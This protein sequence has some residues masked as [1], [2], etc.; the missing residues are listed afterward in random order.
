MLMLFWS[1]CHGF[2]HKH[3]HIENESKLPFGEKTLGKRM[4]GIA[5]TDEENYQRTKLS[6]SYGGNC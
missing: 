1:A 5:Q 2:S 4:K 6:D 3:T